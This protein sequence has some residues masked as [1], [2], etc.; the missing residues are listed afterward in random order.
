M[1]KYYRVR[2]G[3]GGKHVD[4]CLQGGFVGA[5]Y[6]I[7]QD[8]TGKLPSEFRTF[9]QEFIPVYLQRFP[10][11]TKIGAGLSCGQLWTI[12]RGL[13]QGDL[14]IC[15]D[16]GG[17]YHVAEVIGGYEYQPGANLPHRRPVRWLP[18]ALDRADLSEALQASTRGPNTVTEI[19]KYRDEIEG[20]LAGHKAS[21]AI[22]A[23]DETI[24]DPSTFAME[25]HLEAFLIA[26]WQQTDF[27]A[28]F[29]IFE[30][31]GELVGQQ[32]PTDTGPIDIL[33]VRR[34]RKR[35]L[36]IELKKGRASDVVVGQILRYMGYV[37][38]ELA[39]PGQSV[40]GLVIALEEDQRLKRALAMV[41]S[42][43][44]YRYEVSFKLV[45]V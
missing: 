20:L 16:G 44:F 24:E 10:E 28:D 19:T 31:E 12:A 6:G 8:L 33:A 2:L 11:K 36:V 30:E 42:I 37:T 35:L 17:S 41:P 26:N 1:K 23:T 18:G 34:D 3:K 43:D 9:N 14:L 39:E 13:E 29:E 4:E 22:V 40:E 32:Y 21:V 27:A 25:K 38:E 7:E 5:D 15:P 45:K